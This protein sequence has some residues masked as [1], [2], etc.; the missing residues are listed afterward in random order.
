MTDHI[1]LLTRVTELAADK[2]FEA[3]N[4]NYKILHTSPPLGKDSGLIKSF[5]SSLDKSSE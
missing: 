5:E 2:T 3:V 4:S 1:R